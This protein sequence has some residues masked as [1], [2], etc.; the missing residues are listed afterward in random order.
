MCSFSDYLQKNWQTYFVYVRLA[1]GKGNE[2]DLSLI[3][4]IALILAW[5]HLLALFTYTPSG[6]T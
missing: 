3:L 2:I 5:V 6:E 1:I 4:F